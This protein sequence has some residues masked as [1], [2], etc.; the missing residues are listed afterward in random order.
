MHINIKIAAVGDPPTFPELVPFHL[1]TIVGVSIL[2]K[3]MESGHCSAAI[4][5]KDYKGN[6]YTAELS[7]NMLAA[8]GAAAR[9]AKERF[10]DS[11]V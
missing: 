6:N 11:D 3:G 2:E 1:A 9:G 5:F 10:K 8:M 7:A 4:H